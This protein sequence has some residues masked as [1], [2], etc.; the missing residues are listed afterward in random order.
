MP[1]KK[2]AAHKAASFLRGFAV[3]PEDICGFAPG[4]LV[5]GDEHGFHGVNHGLLLDVKPGV[6]GRVLCLA[7]GAGSHIEV[8]GGTLLGVVGEILGGHDGRGG[9]GVNAAGA[10]GVCQKG[11]DCV[12]II[13]GGVAGMEE[14]FAPA[15]LVCGDVFGKP[16]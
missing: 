9:D 4:Q 8:C 16:P 11:R 12:V 14:K 6:V 13:K 15:L 3:F 5:V 7:G 1:R 2:E 10:Q